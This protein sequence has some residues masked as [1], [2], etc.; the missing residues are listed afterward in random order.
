MILQRRRFIWLLAAVAAAPLEAFTPSSPLR[1]HPTTTSFTAAATTTLVEHVQKSCNYDYDADL[2]GSVP[3][4][5]ARSSLGSLTTTS[6]ANHGECTFSILSW[7]ILL[8]NAEDNW[9]NHKMY[10]SGVP[11]EHREWPHRQALIRD[12]LLQVDADIICIQEAAADTFAQDFEFLT[13]EAGY[14]FCIHNKF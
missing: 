4:L 11:M 13:K 3:I 8:P 12:R 9:W 6:R 10:S 2:V 14:E 5:P 1:R 7:N